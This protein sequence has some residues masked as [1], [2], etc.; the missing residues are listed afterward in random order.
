PR[1]RAAVPAVDLSAR[2]QV[3]PAP[4]PAG[5]KRLAQGRVGRWPGLMVP[6]GS[7]GYGTAWRRHTPSPA[8]RM[9]RLRPSRGRI[10]STPT[11]TPAGAEA[12]R[13][14]LRPRLEHP[15]V[16]PQRTGGAAVAAM[17]AGGGD[18]P[19]QA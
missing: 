8:G 11:A 13:L 19:D 15:G 2:I 4:D 3:R 10:H 7:G 9:K 16:L 1:P 12:R 5:E 6:A 18:G 17:D 14:G